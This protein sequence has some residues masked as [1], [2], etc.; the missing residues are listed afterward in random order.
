MPIDLV[1]P[2]RECFMT[3]TAAGIVPVVKVCGNTVGDGRPGDV[4]KRLLREIEG[5][6]ANHRYGLG[7][8]ASRQEVYKYTRAKKSP[9]QL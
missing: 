5:A 6:M 9:I 3:G 1:G 2:G 8:E 4:T 7:I